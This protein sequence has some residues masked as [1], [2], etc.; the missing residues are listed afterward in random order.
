[1]QQILCIDFVSSNFSVFI[2]SNSFL[3][4]FGF[5]IYGSMSSANN[6]TFASFFQIRM[7]L[8]FLLA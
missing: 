5:S 7:I 2:S 8:F 1:M 3:T 4:V 6:D